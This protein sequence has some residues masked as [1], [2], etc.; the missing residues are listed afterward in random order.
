MMVD[1]MEVMKA[2]RKQAVI[3]KG[4]EKQYYLVC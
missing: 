4:S 3:G 2:L 1:K